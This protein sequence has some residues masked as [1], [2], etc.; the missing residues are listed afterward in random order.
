MAMPRFI[1]RS[2]IIV[3]LAAPALWLVLTAEGQR[4]AD[5]F[6]LG[7]GGEPDIPLSFDRLH[8]D[9]P[10][11]QL[12]KEQPELELVCSEKN[13]AFGARLCQAPIAGINGTPARY[14]IFYYG[15]KQ[16][17]A[18]KIGYQRSYHGRI[19]KQL[20]QTLG[21]PEQSQQPDGMINQW[22]AGEGMVVMP[23]SLGEQQEPALMWLARGRNSP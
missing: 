23:E 14:I 18:I 6:I 1:K 7:I 21:T 3:L 10:P 11:E 4:R 20:R 22:P 12:R 17:N 8:P 9:I 5:L 15:P 13:T 2:L 16:L 19:V